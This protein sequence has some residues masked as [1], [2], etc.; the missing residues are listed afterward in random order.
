MM[1]LFFE[2]WWLFSFWSISA[3]LFVFFVASVNDKCTLKHINIG[4][5]RI[6]SKVPAIRK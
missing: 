2:A 5:L 4:R 3:W 1:R 6:C